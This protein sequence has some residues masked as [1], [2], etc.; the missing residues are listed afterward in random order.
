MFKI[1]RI[2]QPRP[3]QV[4]LMTAAAAQTQ[5]RTPVKR[6]GDISDSFISLSGTERPPLP[7]R[8]LDLK[9]AL[10]A[11]HEH[12]VVESWKRL[13]GRLRAEN[14]TIAREGPMIIPNINFHELDKDLIKFGAEIRKRG[15]LV[16]RNVV[17][18]KEARAYKGEIEE[19]ARRNPSTRD[20]PQ[21]FELYWSAPQ[22]KARAHPNLLKAQTALMRLWKSSDPESEI[23]TSQPLIYADR[24]RIRQP[25]DANF[26]LGPHIDGGSVERWEPH[27][28]G[29][30]GVY[31]NIFEGAWEEYDPWDA[32]TRVPAATNNYNGLGGCSMFRM[33]QGWL[34]MSQTRPFEG[35]LM[36]NPVLQPSTA[37]ML[38]RPFFQPIKHVGQVSDDEY[39]ST[40]N[41]E[42]AGASMT[43]ELQGA[44]PG[45]GQELSTV[46]HPHLELKKT[47]VHV[48]EIRP[49]D[50]VA[51]HCDID[52]V[53]QGKSDSSVLTA[54]LAGTPG[55]DFPGGKGES[56]HVNRPDYA[57][58]RS[59]ADLSGL[60]AHGFGKLNPTA[61][62]TKGAKRVMELA[63]SILGF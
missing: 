5:P 8:F 37:Y 34:S 51:W 15:V 42:F 2:D 26:A 19:Y 47:M 50:Y 17:P 27:G 24:L 28:Y 14:Q 32:S 63:N 36:V 61:E 58:L 21:V 45:H 20:N 25:G 33:F 35:T 6:E 18:E 48:P 23:S 29:R 22:I 9:K 7:P 40:D 38:L 43:S 12:R 44:T 54:F 52:Q 62:D 56:E 60:R 57:Y 53:H 31:H 59:H 1:S 41:W 4:R 3:C 39:L 46:L 11:G 10:I 16:V 13:L 55:P 30:G 49:G